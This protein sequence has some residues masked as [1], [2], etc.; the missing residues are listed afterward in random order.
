MD[1]I[2]LSM[3]LWVYWL[4]LFT[5]WKWV[6]RGILSWVVNQLQLLTM[7]KVNI[8]FIQSLNVCWLFSSQRIPTWLPLHGPHS[9]LLSFLYKDYLLC[10][11]SP[12]FLRNISLLVSWDVFRLP[13]VSW[14]MDKQNVIY[15]F[16]YKMD[17]YSALKRKENLIHA[18]HGWILNKHCACEI[19]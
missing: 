13:P 7:L 10:S 9:T 3:L 5:I 6:R 1:S 2:T 12:L 19:R 17:Y 16:L 11:L 4:V 15:A 14:L 18:R 8:R